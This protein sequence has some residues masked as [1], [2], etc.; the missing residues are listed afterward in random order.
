MRLNVAFLIIVAVGLCSAVRETPIKDARWVFDNLM[1]I[2]RDGAIDNHEILKFGCAHSSHSDCGS[3]E[4]AETAM[5]YLDRDFSQT[6]SFNEFVDA[7]MPGAKSTQFYPLQP[8]PQQVHLSLTGD[9]TQMVIMWV[10]AS[11]KETL[12]LYGV[13]MGSYGMNATGI[14]TTYD[15]GIDGWRGVIHTVTLY[16]L[17]P[18]TKYYYKVGNGHDWSIDYWFTTA[19][20]VGTPGV[21]IATVADMG[22]L[23]MGWGVTNQIIGDNSVTPFSFVLHA[24]DVAY[25]GTGKEWEIEEV[26]D[27]WCDQMNN[28]GSIVP[29]MFAVGNHEKY[30]NYTSFRHRFTMP[31]LQSGGEGNFWWSMDYGNVHVVAFSTEHPLG[32]GFPQRIWLE[33][34]LQRAAANR[35]QTPWIIMSGHRPMYNSDKDEWNDHHEGAWFQQNIEPLMLKYGVD[36][37][38]C[39][40]MHMYERV[41]PVI[42]GVPQQTGNTYTNPGAPMH[43]VQGNS[44][45]VLDLPYK[46]L[47][48]QPSWSAYRASTWGYGNMNFINSTHLHY[49]MRRFDT[50]H[51]D[52]EFWL[53]KTN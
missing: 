47:D 13:T 32:D 22:I 42:N 19:P 11:A 4:Q 39:G 46:F 12:V 15:A 24:G 48:P 29:Y 40:H 35:G 34:D 20:S 25:A 33:Q 7:V 27:L 9:P 51:V 44:G 16:N 31:S 28:L 36:L 3:I 30:Y 37:Y 8:S 26:W 53:I 38:L 14:T 17:R 18:S 1:D 23:P 49:E 52:D 10:T 41:H 50:G 2:N 5:K 43:I 6:I 45:I 21:R